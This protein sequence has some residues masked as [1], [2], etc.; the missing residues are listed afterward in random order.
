MQRF[1]HHYQVAITWTDN[2]GSGTARS[3]DK[4][5]ILVYNPAKSKHIYTLAGASRNTAIETIILPA[6]FSG[7][8][9]EVWITFISA[10]NKSIS[11]S[12]YAGNIGGILEYIDDEVLHPLMIFI[13]EY[14]GG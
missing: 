12:I 7:D 14:T 5:V 1:S 2:S 13:F 10:N 8:R 4:A 6:D 9:V 3:T 11:T